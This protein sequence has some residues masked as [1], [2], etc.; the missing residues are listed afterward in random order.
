MDACM[1]LYEG[2]NDEMI[3][4]RNHAY[5]YTMIPASHH[6]LVTRLMFICWFPSV[7]QPFY[8]NVKNGVTRAHLRWTYQPSWIS[9]TTKDDSSPIL[10]FFHRC[11]YLY[12]LGVVIF[13]CAILY[14]YILYYKHL[15]SKP[16]GVNVFGRSIN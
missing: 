15:I 14:I 16:F 11:L 1:F 12:L 3:I 2:E 7:N 13:M 5:Y 10:V 4:Y 9:G 6:M 8:K